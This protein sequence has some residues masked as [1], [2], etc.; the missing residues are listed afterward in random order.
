MEEKGDIV[1]KAKSRGKIE[2]EVNKKMKGSFQ[3][4]FFLPNQLQQMQSLR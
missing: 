2:V 3:G 1:R 4:T